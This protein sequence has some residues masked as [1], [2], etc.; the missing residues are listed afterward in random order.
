MTLCW[1]SLRMVAEILKGNIRESYREQSQSFL[2]G[3]KVTQLLIVEHA[4]G[5]RFL[6]Q[7]IRSQGKQYGQQRLPQLNLFTLPPLTNLSARW[8]SPGGGLPGILPPNG[9]YFKLRYLSF[10]HAQNYSLNHVNYP[11]V[12]G[13]KASVVNCKL[14]KCLECKLLRPATVT[15]LSWCAGSRTLSRT[16]KKEYLCVNVLF[17]HPL[18]RPGS[19]GKPLQLMPSCEKHYLNLGQVTFTFEFLVK[20]VSHVKQTHRA[21]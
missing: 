17:I 14:N 21:K 7:S 11:Q 5:S 15:N 12:C 19:V 20:D 6:P 16:G 18:F 9:I 4:E 3:R 1:D 13:L 10:N 8:P 2:E